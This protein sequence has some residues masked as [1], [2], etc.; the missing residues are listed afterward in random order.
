[1][2]KPTLVAGSIIT[3]LSI[4]LAANTI[5]ILLGVCYETAADSSPQRG[6]DCISDYF[7][8][9][10]F[11]SGLVSAIF[12]SAIGIWFLALGIK[13]IS[14]KAAMTRTAFVIGFLTSGV[15][16][17]LVAMLSVFLTLFDEEAAFDY[18]DFVIEYAPTLIP[19]GVISFLLGLTGLIIYYVKSPA[20]LLMWLLV[21]A[22]FVS[23]GSL[24]MFGSPF[25]LLI[26]V[27]VFVATY[28]I[29]HKRVAD[30]RNIVIA[31]VALGSIGIM[32]AIA[33]AET[34]FFDYGNVEI[35]PEVIV[36]RN[37]VVDSVDGI[38]LA[39]VDNASRVLPPDCLKSDQ[40]CRARYGEGLA[41]LE[42]Y[43]GI[44]ADGQ[45]IISSTITNTGTGTINVTDF[46]IQG[47]S[48]TFQTELVAN[49][50]E[51]SVSG[52]SF[53]GPPFF[54][55]GFSQYQSDA[56][57][58]EPVALKPNESLTMH[59]K[60]NWSAE[61]GKAISV[62]RS[63]ASYNYYLEPNIWNYPD[64]PEQSVCVP[65]CDISP[66]LISTPR[67]G[68]L[69]TYYDGDKHIH[70]AM[71][72]IRSPGLSYVGCMSNHDA[73][74]LF[75]KRNLAVDF[76]S[77]L[78][79]GFSSV[80]IIDSDTQWML[81][82]IANSTAMREEQFRQ[83]P[84]LLA[85]A[86]EQPGVITVSTQLTPWQNFNDTAFEEYSYYIEN[87]DPEYIGQV[88]FQVIRGNSVVIQENYWG[89]SVE[90]NM[91]GREYYI[92]G[93]VPPQELLRVAESLM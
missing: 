67:S 62:F 35:R 48:T 42:M 76:P 52:I 61:Q 92:T 2:H 57:I 45:Q 86:T 16:M 55:F 11:L 83:D 6:L 69:S 28:W 47:S 19:V 51:S 34:M 29:L 68:S 31:A 56:P 24:V 77:Y 44:A 88:S 36:E 59:I 85:D 22:A 18:N 46:G 91:N 43:Y 8:F 15:A 73:T 33:Y 65:G 13:S 78:P 12:V 41:G 10:L 14:A 93:K 20:R 32:A 82:I 25:G 3:F 80:C 72:E 54:L 4:V 71:A 40:D 63:S 53:G 89:T 84:R 90:V 37:Q 39:R 26:G 64:S 75:A 27:A 50:V 49:A 17:L 9:Q 66:E 81:Q 1:M 79:E 87:N 7:G 70:D 38:A 60:G 21:F 58:T 23:V 30:A 5:S 74:F